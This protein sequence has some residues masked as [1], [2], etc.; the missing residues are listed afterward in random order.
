MPFFCL[1]TRLKQQV[2]RVNDSFEF[3][4]LK[5]FSL[6][7]G[8]IIYL[9]LFYSIHQ[10]LHIVSGAFFTFCLFSYYYWLRSKRSFNNYN[11]WFFIS[12]RA[13]L[14]DRFRLHFGHFNDSL[15]LTLSESLPHFFLKSQSFLVKPCNL[16]S[17]SFIFFLD[18]SDLVVVHEFLLDFLSLDLFQLF[19]DLWEILLQ[20]ILLVGFLWVIRAVLSLIV[21]LVEIIWKLTF[22]LK[23]ELKIEEIYQRPYFFLTVS[24]EALVTV[25]ALLASLE[26]VAHLRAVQLLTDP[27]GYRNLRTQLWRH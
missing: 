27:W 11:F 21:L 5:L 1:R 26:V 10:V 4:I 22:G 9:R 25:L 24:K 2:W 3:K 17:K 14:D 23:T 13:N 12:L 6:F 8:G 15:P 18:L 19:L 20:L 16:I 7:S